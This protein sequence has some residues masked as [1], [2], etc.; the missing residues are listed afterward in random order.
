MTKRAFITGISGQDGSYLC[1]FLLEK[2]YDVFGII[3]PNT[4]NLFN[5]KKCLPYIKII[6]CDI[7]DK[8]LKNIILDNNPNELYHLASESHISYENI[9]QTIET[10]STSTILIMDILKNNLPD[11]KMFN[12]GS[13]QMYGYSRDSDG[14]QREKT[15]FNPVNP[16]GCSKLLSYNISLI[17]RNKFK[18]NVTNGFLFNHESPRRGDNFVTT[19]IIK[20]AI[21][22][23]KGTQTQITL[24][25]LNGHR[26]WSH[27]KD[28]V[29]GM[30]LTQ[31]KQSDDYVFASGRMSSVEYVCNYVFD[32]LN[33]NFKKYSKDIQ[34]TSSEDEPKLL[35]NPTKLKQ[36]TGWKPKYTLESMLDEM[37]DHHY[38][39][40][41]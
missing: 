37:I 4:K 24:K 8:K 21:K 30:W 33:L 20:D 41:S 25:S 35:G 3:R 19:K 14:Y 26:D 10:I 34:M 23:K 27:A 36:Q 12:A 15:Q 32:K 31:Q 11:C 22:I 6:E 1:E 5:L 39:C 17:Y 13:S 38:E 2:G 40:M 28:F 18:L 7:R 29:E 9:P 16:Y